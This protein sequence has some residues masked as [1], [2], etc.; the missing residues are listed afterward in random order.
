[1]G[2]RFLRGLSL[3]RLWREGCGGAPL[4]YRRRLLMIKP[5]QPGFARGKT[6]QPPFRA[7][8]IPLWWL[9]PPPFR[10]VGKRV[11]GFSVAYGSL[12]IQFPC[13]R[14]SVGRQKESALM[15]RLGA[16]LRPCGGPMQDLHRGL[17]GSAKPC[18]HKSLY[19]KH[20]LFCSRLRGKSGEA[21]KGEASAASQSAECLSCHMTLK[22]N[23]VTF[24][25]PL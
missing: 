14:S 21:G 10:P 12:R 2:R 13:H 19:F 20:G 11:T 16:L 24:L 17:Q 9:A 1:M 22:V 25:R 3:T 7:R 18:T 4:N 6:G 15:G 8:E 23:P 5:L